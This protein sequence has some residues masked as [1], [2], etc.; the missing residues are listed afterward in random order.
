MFYMYRTCFVEDHSTTQYVHCKC[1]KKRYMTPH[2]C[3]LSCQWSRLG[4]FALPR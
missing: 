1:N 3:F 4:H 2:Y